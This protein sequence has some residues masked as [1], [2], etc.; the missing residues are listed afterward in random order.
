MASNLTDQVHS[1]SEVA[2]AVEGGDLTKKIEDGVPGEI[3][4]LKETMNKMTE[5]LSVLWMR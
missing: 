2:M 5:S 4:E 1:L 3:L